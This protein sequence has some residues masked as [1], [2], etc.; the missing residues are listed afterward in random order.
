MFLKMR[1]SVVP[2]R[3]YIRSLEYLQEPE[4]GSEPFL[5]SCEAPRMTLSPLLASQ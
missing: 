4:K 3:E 1:L 5:P 2:I